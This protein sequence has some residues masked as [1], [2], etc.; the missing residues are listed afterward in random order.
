MARP[1]QPHNC[2]QPSCH[3]PILSNEK[4]IAVTLLAR[5]VGMGSQ[6]SSK[7]QLIY[8][9]PQCAFRYATGRTPRDPVQLAF[10]KI[11]LDLAGQWRD[12]TEA[13]FQQ[14]EGR[15][16]EVLYPETMKQVL[17]EGEALEG[18]T[19]GEVVAEPRQ[20]KEAS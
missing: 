1:S 3:R 7:S 18:K 6:R 12:V 15:R 5:T 19:E 14:L 13:A 2:C 8:L 17:L 11:V 10:F 20:L 4:A 16:Q 9:C